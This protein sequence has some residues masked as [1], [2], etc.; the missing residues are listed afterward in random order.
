MITREE[1]FAIAELYLSEHRVGISVEYVC[2]PFEI[3]AS[4]PLVYNLNLYDCW[5]AY[6]NQG[7]ST[8]LCS[9]TIVAINK[10]NGRI[11]YAGTANDE[12]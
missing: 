7:Y 3:R 4:K 12:G 10:F 6:I 11:V 5:I 2:C 9:S 1:A 8:L